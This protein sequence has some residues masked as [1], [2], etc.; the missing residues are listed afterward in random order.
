MLTAGCT[1]RVSQGLAVVKKVL[2]SSR[3][4]TRLSAIIT[5]DQNYIAVQLIANRTREIVREG[6]KTKSLDRCMLVGK[7]FG[8]R[9]PTVISH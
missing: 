6:R 8:A 1:L 9:T 5:I 2:L 7:G 4:L 3:V